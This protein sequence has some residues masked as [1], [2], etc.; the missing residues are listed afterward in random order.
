M[1]GEIHDI[2][3]WWNE[4]WNAVFLRHAKEVFGESNG[5]IIKNKE[6]WFS[7]RR[8]SKIPS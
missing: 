3:V 6:T 8:Y 7:L 2:D 5:K 4:R 1:N